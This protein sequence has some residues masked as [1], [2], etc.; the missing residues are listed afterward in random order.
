MAGSR[1]ACPLR[2]LPGAIFVIGSNP[3]TC[4]FA[5][6]VDAAYGGAG[7]G[8]TLLATLI[9]VAR[10]RKLAEMEGFVLADNKSML[11]LATRVGFSI[12]RDPNDH[13][14]RICKLQL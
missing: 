12:E 9:E 10:Q 5:L 2:S 8:R 6:S 13:G 1:P 14:I 11:R 3:T 4:E 7:L